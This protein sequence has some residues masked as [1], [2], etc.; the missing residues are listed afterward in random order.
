MALYKE[1]DRPLEIESSL[2]DVICLLNFIQRI[3]KEKS[4]VTSVINWIT[5]TRKES[6]LRER[7]IR[8]YSGEGI[9]R[10]PN[11]GRL[12]RCHHR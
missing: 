3:K 4:V 10:V 1:N 12:K 2:L 8:T 11:E 9:I 7:M 5:R 6:E